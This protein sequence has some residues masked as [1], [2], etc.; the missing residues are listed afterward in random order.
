[1]ETDFSSRAH[2]P[3]SSVL[4]TSH[5]GSNCSPPCEGAVEAEKEVEMRKRERGRRGEAA[6]ESTE[7]VRGRGR[8]TFTGLLPSSWSLLQAGL[9]ERHRPGEGEGQDGHFLNSCGLWATYIAF[10]VSCHWHNAEVSLPAPCHRR[11]NRKL[12]QGELSLPSP[13]DSQQPC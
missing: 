10:W 12:R 9:R 8:A 5:S 3:D 1:M 2:L 6:E 4:L 7:Q 13:G 11:E